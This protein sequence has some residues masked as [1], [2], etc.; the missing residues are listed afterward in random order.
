LFGVLGEHLPDNKDHNEHFAKSVI[1]A[2]H[3]GEHCE[4]AG[5]AAQALTGPHL[6]RHFSIADAFKNLQ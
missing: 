3:C 2:A 5:A 4:A 1:G 6:K